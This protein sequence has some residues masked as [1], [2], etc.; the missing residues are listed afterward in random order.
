[1]DVGGTR[2]NVSQEHFLD[3]LEFIYHEMINILIGMYS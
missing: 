2:T 3:N 1:M